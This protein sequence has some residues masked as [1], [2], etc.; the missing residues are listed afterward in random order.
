MKYLIFKETGPMLFGN[1]QHH[2]IMGYSYS[3]I[4]Y[5]EE[6]AIIAGGE[7]KLHFGAGVDVECFGDA[8]GIKGV[9]CRGVEDAKLI[10][11]MLGK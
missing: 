9:V 7:C 10:A 11:Q 2:N 4:G 3:D 5:S 1:D 6:D 8:E